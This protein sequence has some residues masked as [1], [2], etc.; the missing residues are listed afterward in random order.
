MQVV[1]CK[2]CGERIFL[3]GENIGRNVSY[4]GTCSECG[5]IYW[6]EWDGRTGELIF[7]KVIKK[8]KKQE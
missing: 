4:Y 5:R 3:S 2:H 8:Y 7:E 1:Y 6:G